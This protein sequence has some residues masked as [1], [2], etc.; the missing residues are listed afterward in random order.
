MVACAIALRMALDPVLESRLELITL[1]AALVPLAW[2]LSGPCFWVC[3]IA[4][5]V[6]ATWFIVEPRGAFSADRPAVLTG[7]LFSFMIIAGLWYSVRRTRVARE[8][9]AAALA[10]EHEALA[11]LAAIVRSSEDAIISKNRDG[12]I[13]SFNAAAERLFGYRESEAVGK[14]ITLLVPEDLRAEEADIMSRLLRGERIEQFETTR[15]TKDG[16]PV[17]VLL[18]ISPVRDAAGNVVGAAKIARDVSARRA[19]ER[20]R[21]HAAARVAQIISVLPDMIFLCEVPSGRPLLINPAVGLSLGYSYEELDHFGREVMATIIHPDDFAHVKDRFTQ[22]VSL[23]DGEAVEMEHRARRKDGSWAILWV[24][25]TPFERDAEGR[26]TVVL[27]VDRDVTLDRE[28]QDQ[29]AEYR[30][31]L[32]RLVEER[33]A[34]L[35]ASHAK[36]RAAERMAAL[37]TLS[38]G[39]GHDIGNLVLPLRLRI[40]SLRRET[41][42]GMVGGDLDAIEGGLSYIQRLSQSLRLL[43][44]DPS[45][46]RQ[47]ADDV[48]DIAQWWGVAQPLLMAVLPRTARL[49]WTQSDEGLY[50]AMSQHL[51]LQS[52]FNLVQN[53]AEAMADA[54]TREPRVQVSVQAAEGPQGPRVRVSVRDNG[55]GMTDSIRNSCME[56]FFSTKARQLS[57][58]M[59]LSLVAGAVHA[60]GGNVSVESTPG[61][62][63]C[64]TLDLPAASAP[65]ADGSTPFAAHVLASISV[66][67]AR[68][69]AYVQWVLRAAGMNARLLAPAD[70]PASGLWVVEPSLRAEAVRYATADGRWAM[71]LESPDRAAGD[72]Q[73]N[74]ETSRVLFAGPRPGVSDIQ[75]LLRAAFEVG[76]P[77]KEPV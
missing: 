71:V 30:A 56:P 6:G 37:G 47:S 46:P 10:H 32:E 58:G 21:D 7:F 45:D 18:S 38:R 4:G 19:F 73:E 1:W 25:L 66:N 33:T 3:A 57:G 76:P 65:P 20:E 53:A 60:A 70:Q 63:T 14:H 24:R 41:P 54:K 39:L 44:V 22:A 51:L 9:A 69:R 74:G 72:G 52:V 11:Q 55:P 27:A 2:L 49:E 68:A 48:T 17:E 77:L 61:E 40:E 43:A 12:I 64:F 8:D 16:R 59:G 34:A 28:Q 31:G 67:D 13:R 29:L 26:T 62:G 5:L 35:E 36:L 42:A 23:A 15:R 75:R 50:V